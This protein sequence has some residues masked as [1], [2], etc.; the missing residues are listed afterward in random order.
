MIMTINT[1]NPVDQNSLP[2]GS[3]HIT[4]CFN[5]QIS[6]DQYTEPC[7]SMLKFLKINTHNPV[8]QCSNF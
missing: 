2:R 4:L 1:H 7:G 5:A 6:K 3:I 8:F